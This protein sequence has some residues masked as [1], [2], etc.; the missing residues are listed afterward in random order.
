MGVAMVVAPLLAIIPPHAPWLIGV[1]VLGD[2]LARRRLHEH[3]TVT[4]VRGKCPKCG[5][6]ISSGAGRLRTPHPLPCEACHH[7]ATLKLPEGALDV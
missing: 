4:A 3:F 1:L 5:A 2:V 7:D 6:E